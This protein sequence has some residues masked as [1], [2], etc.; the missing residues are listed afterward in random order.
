MWAGY[1]IA[2]WQDAAIHMSDLVMEHT[3]DFGMVV[4]RR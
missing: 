1:A 4:V 2:H 3:L